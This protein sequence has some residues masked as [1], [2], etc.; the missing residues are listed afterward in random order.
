MK[1]QNLTLPAMLL[2]AAI[3]SSCTTKQMVSCPDYSSDRSVMVKNGK[4]YK[5]KSHRYRPVVKKRQPAL[6]AV[7]TA[8]KETP[9]T[10]ANPARVEEYT[11]AI[12]N[13]HTEEIPVG[14]VAFNAGII[15]EN[16]TESINNEIEKYSLTAEVPAEQRTSPVREVHQES[17]DQVVPAAVSAESL[18]TI[19]KKV[20]KPER[21][22]KKKTRKF[23]RRFLANKPAIGF[24]TASL[25]SSLLGLLIAGIPLGILAIIFGG[26]AMKRIK[27]DPGQ[28]GLGLATAGLIVGIAD[29]VL[30]L[31]ALAMM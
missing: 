29:V 17:T 22:T 20:V 13:S 2:V 16:T 10:N 9:E 8:P 26:V 24:A 19:D 25:V 30:V 21:H 28:P 18:R 12:V 15:R 7:R 3:V 6:A 23:F 1:R 31:I 4:S 5:S 11:P 27:D 14:K